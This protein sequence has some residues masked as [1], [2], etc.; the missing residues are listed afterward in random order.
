M[1]AYQKGLLF[2]NWN[3]SITCHQIFVPGWVDRFFGLP[4]LHQIIFW[5][6]VQMFRLLALLS[7]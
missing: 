6:I 5:S 1:I 7:N 2:V 4:H 3:F